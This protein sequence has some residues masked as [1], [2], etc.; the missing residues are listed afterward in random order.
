MDT[1]YW[2]SS[3]IKQFQRAFEEDPNLLEL[4]RSL[5][6]APYDLIKELSAVD[7]C[8]RQFDKTLLRSKTFLHLESQFPESSRITSQDL[9]NDELSELTRINK[10]F[11]NAAS[12]FESMASD[13]A[14]V[15]ERKLEDQTDL[16]WDYEMDAKVGFQLHHDDPA[17]SDE[18]DNL[19]K[20]MDLHLSNEK[21]NP[22]DWK[23]IEM[24]WPTG[25]CGDPLPRGKILHLL[26]QNYPNLSAHPPVNLRDVARVRGLWLDLKVAY[27]LYYDVKEGKWVKTMEWPDGKAPVLTYVDD[28]KLRK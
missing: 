22:T 11:V 21:E 14:T 24:D 19:L 4:F 15:L 26:L 7:D 23:I 2:F 27:Q 12:Q 8:I 9:P 10:E 5:E 18:D 20:E 13:M 25:Y 16:L 1:M 17:F 6:D 28:S 3:R